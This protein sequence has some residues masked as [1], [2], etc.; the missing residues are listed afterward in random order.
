MKLSIKLFGAFF[1]ILAIVVGAM[2]FSRY[3]FSRNFR[4]YIQQVEQERLQQMVPSLV[5][6]YRAQAGWEKI[7]A[8]HSRWEDL[9][10]RWSDQ[11]SD[12]SQQRDSRFHD[13]DRVLLSDDN[14]HPIV[15]TPGP[16]DQARL[17]AVNIDGRTVGWLGLKK[18]EQFKGPPAALMERQNRDLFLLGCAVIG[19]TALIAVL[20]SRHLLQ[21]IQ[22][23]THGTQELAER[24]FSVRIAST[25]RDELGQLAK[26]FNTMAETLENLE[27]MRQ[28]WL[29]DISHELR[30][31]LAVL[32]GEVEALQDGIREATPKNLA[33]LHAEILRLGKLV[34]DIH[35]LSMA[36]ADTLSISERSVCPHTVLQNVLE[37]HQGRFLQCQIEIE[38]AVDEIAEVVIKGDA[39]R[40]E[41]VFT[42]IFDNVCKYVPASGLLRVSGWVHGSLLQFYFQDSGPGV[43]DDALPRLFDRLYRVDA[44]RNRDTGGSGLGLSICRQIIERHGGKIWAEKSPAG[45]LCIGLEL[46]L[47]KVA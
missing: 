19:L 16:E 6:A 32:R 18:R 42:N 30:T 24:N 45:G 20:F 22:R 47:E 13:I 28:Q 35:M 25:T 21:P 46:P 31:P 12:P 7:R 4:E 10:D 23:L 37:Y 39:D 8:D 11:Q 5:E 38:T 34:E 43:P 1:L 9:L 36:D 3:L 26:N 44:S 33:S 29:T 27:G 17:V 15:G 2:F 40:L 41:Q 14:L